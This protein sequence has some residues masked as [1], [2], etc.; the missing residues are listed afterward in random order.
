MTLCLFPLFINFCLPNPFSVLLP[1]LP[2]IQ[3]VCEHL[4]YAWNHARPWTICGHSGEREPCFLCSQGVSCLLL[5]FWSICLASLALLLQA[6]TPI[7]YLFLNC[8]LYHWFLTLNP[9]CF[10]RGYSA[11]HWQLISQTFSGSKVLCSG[12]VGAFV[13]LPKAFNVCSL[14]DH[15]QWNDEMF[16]GS[17]TSLK[18]F[19]ESTSLMLS[20]RLNACLRW[21]RSDSALAPILVVLKQFLCTEKIL[22][23]P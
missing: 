11:W 12:P 17:I 5:G 21:C 20:N 2:F 22:M 19:L 8:D 18:K 23:F 6:L 14:H 10:T 16:K 15:H 1:W 9:S 7:F 13:L 3:Q 4:F